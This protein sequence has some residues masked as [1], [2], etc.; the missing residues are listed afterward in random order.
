M[1][2][3]SKYFPCG[4]RGFKR[5]RSLTFRSF[6]G[7][8]YTWTCKLQVYCKLYL[9]FFCKSNF[10]WQL[11]HSSRFCINFLLKQACICSPEWCKS[12]RNS[13]TWLMASLAKTILREPYQPAFS[14]MFSANDAIY[15]WS[16]KLLAGYN[17]MNKNV[18]KSIWFL[19]LRR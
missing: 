8:S 10:K 5:S 7:I 18:L 17:L 14:G 6:L 3:T 2:K 16:T 9:S 19:T 13:L 4:S 1:S 11:K 15:T 12:T